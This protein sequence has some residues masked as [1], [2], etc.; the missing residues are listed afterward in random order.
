M[1]FKTNIFIDFLLEDLQI[2]CIFAHSKV[3]EAIYQ[4]KCIN[5]AKTLLVTFT[6]LLLLISF[7]MFQDFSWLKRSYKKIKLISLIS[8]ISPLDMANCAT[9][10]PKK[11]VQVVGV[12]SNGRE[13]KPSTRNIKKK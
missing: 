1:Y 9:P 2:C 12:V 11:V 4:N 10:P 7:W 13:F 6:A 8:A 3:K 5:S